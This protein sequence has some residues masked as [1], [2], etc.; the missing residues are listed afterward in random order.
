M[1]FI[2]PVMIIQKL[3][4]QNAGKEYSIPWDAEKEMGCLC[5]IGFAWNRYI[6]T[7]I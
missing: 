2:I 3:L 4:A 5:D 6:W 7:G 1:S